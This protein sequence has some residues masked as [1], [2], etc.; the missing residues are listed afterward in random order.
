MPLKKGSSQKT[1]S[2]NIRELVKDNKK[3]GK[4]KGAMGV[5][6]PMKQIVAIALSMAGKTK[7][8]MKKKGMK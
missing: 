1:I 4:T 7:K 6:R 5:A 2:M 3:T 8:Q